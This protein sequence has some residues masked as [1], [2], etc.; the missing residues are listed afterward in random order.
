[1]DS[2]YRCKF[3]RARVEQFRY[4]CVPNSMNVES[5]LHAY[6]RVLFWWTNMQ[7][8]LKYTMSLHELA[9]T[10]RNSAIR[11]CLA[12]IVHMCILLLSFPTVHACMK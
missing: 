1:M 3:M 7:Y 11:E 6:P 2:Q 8:H 9:S 12:F 5:G 10:C 4:A